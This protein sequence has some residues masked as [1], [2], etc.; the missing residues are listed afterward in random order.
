M[1]MR[2]FKWVWRVIIGWYN[3]LFHKMSEDACRRYEI[4]KNCDKI[5]KIGRAKW[6]SVCGCAIPQKCASPEEHCSIGK[7]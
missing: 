1:V 2:F 4:C 6:C 5:I 3:V 7:W